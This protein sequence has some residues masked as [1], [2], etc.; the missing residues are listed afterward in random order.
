MKTA[1]VLNTLQVVQDNPTLDDS[2]MATLLIEHFYFTEGS[3]W[4]G[5]FDL[6]QTIRA[7][8]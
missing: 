3:N 7:T 6:V 8:L 2:K 4:H 5:V 1:T